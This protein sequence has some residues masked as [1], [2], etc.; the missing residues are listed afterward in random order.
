MTAIEPRIHRDGSGAFHRRHELLAVD[1]S[2][3][4]AGLEDDM[5]RF[6]LT[7]RHDG[8]RVTGVEGRAVRWPWQPCVES[9]AALQALV[10][11]PLNPFPAAVGAWADARSQCTHLFDLAGVAIAHAARHATEGAARRSY[12]AVVPDWSEAPYVAWILRDGREVLRWTVGTDSSITDGP[13][14]FP[15]ARLNRRFLEWCREHLDD[16]TAEAAF[17]LRRAAWMSPAR[18]MD[19]EAIATIEGSRIGRGVCYSTQPGRIEIA[20]RNRNSLR[21]YGKR[22]EELLSGFPTAPP[23]SSGLR[24]P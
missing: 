23:S 6:E 10:G 7:L 12:L 19:L 8:Q 22:P 16:D 9:P 3:V 13:A 2:T 4:V 17:L 21:D 18:H 5:H 11:A 14:P 1:A 15:G 24:S 20:R